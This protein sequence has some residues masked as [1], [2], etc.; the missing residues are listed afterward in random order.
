M[1]AARRWRRG[2]R[3]RWRARR[4]AARSRRGRGPRRGRRVLDQ[5]VASSRAGMSSKDGDHVVGEVAVQR[6]GRCRRAS[7]RKAWPSPKIDAAL[8]LQLGVAR[9]DRP[10]R[11]RLPCGTAVTSTWPVSRSTSTSAAP[12]A[13]CQW[14]A[15]DALPRLRVEP[16]LG[17]VRA[18]PD[19]LLVAAARTSTWPMRHAALGACR[20]RRRARRRPRRPAARPPAGSRP[21]SGAGCGRPRRRTARP[22]PSRTSSG[23]TSWTGRTA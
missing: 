11:R 17:H 2:W 22:C 9:V 20:A 5:A 4:A 3:C 15:A 6:A 21:A 14:T 16:A 8:V 12:A 10:A 19:D 1:Q 7:P 13:W 23:W 18:V